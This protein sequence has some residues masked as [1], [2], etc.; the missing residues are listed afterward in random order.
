MKGANNEITYRKG[1]YSISCKDC[2]KHYIS[3]TQCNLEKNQWT[4]TINQNKWQPKCPFLPHERSQT[5]ISFS[6]SH[7]N[8][9]HTQQKIQHIIRICS[10]FQN[11][12]HKTTSRFLSDFILLGRDYTAWK[13]YQ[14]ESGCWNSGNHIVFS[15]G[16]LNTK[17]YVFSVTRLEYILTLAV[18]CPCSYM[19]CWSPAATNWC[20]EIVAS[21]L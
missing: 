16:I 9:T 3:K 5:H 7:S 18:N 17:R 19:L 10:H 4:Q 15:C 1:I 11:K 13:Q 2:N 21:N 12:Q 14:M 20:L 8:Q 6:S